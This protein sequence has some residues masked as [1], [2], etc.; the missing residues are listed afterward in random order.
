M[1]RDAFSNRTDFMG[2][3]ELGR[4]WSRVVS[5]GASIAAR[6]E[7]ILAVGSQ[8]IAQSHCK[9]SSLWPCSRERFPQ[10]KCYSSAPAGGKGVS[11]LSCYGFALEK[12]YRRHPSVQSASDEK[13]QLAFE[14]ITPDEATWIRDDRNTAH[15]GFIPSQ[16]FGIYQATTAYDTPLL[17]KGEWIVSCHSGA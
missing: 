4:R 12:Y 15:P 5:M 14:K 3:L 6:M 8:R 2:E 10:S 13:L 16:L 11:L 9:L 1:A 7:G 17:R